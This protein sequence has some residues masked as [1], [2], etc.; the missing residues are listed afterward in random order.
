MF[1]FNE[2][3]FSVLKEIWKLVPFQWKELFGSKR[4]LKIHSFSM[5]GNK[6]LALKK[7]ENS[8]LFIE[9]ELFGFKKV[10]FRSDRSIRIWQI[11][12]ESESES[13][14]SDLIWIQIRIGSEFDRSDRSES[15]R[16]TSSTVYSIGVIYAAICNLPR[17]IWFKRENLLTL[18]LLP[19]PSEVSLHKINHYLVPIIDEL[20]LL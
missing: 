8:S 20:K 4:D 5:K 16:N 11:R 2:R 13:D 15:V 1:L 6:F 7:S 12:S 3:N 10:E 19:G 18:G 17:D 14:G 9:K